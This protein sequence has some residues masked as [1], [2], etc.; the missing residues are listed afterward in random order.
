MVFTKL[1]V[2]YQIPRTN[3]LKNSFPN[4]PLRLDVCLGKLLTFCRLPF[5]GLRKTPEEKPLFT[6]MLKIG[7]AQ[8]VPE[9]EMN[10]EAE[11]DGF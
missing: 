7:M 8:L 11:D 1:S 3:C 9:E 4:K 6:Q 2:N 10:E 5:V